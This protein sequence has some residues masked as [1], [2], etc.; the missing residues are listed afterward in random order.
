[1]ALL[2]KKQIQER[3]DIHYRVIQVPQWGN[4]EIKLRSLLLEEQF[5]INSL[6][7]RKDVSESDKILEVIVMCCVDD[8]NN[9]LFEPE[10][11]AW[12]KT[13]SPDAIVHIFNE[14]MNMV[15]I[16]D[17]KL[18]ERAKTPKTSYDTFLILFSKRVGNDTEGT[19]G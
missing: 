3:D 12:L 2:N 13:K 10:D 18:E 14:I 15:S 4:D 17:D 9:Q 11:K 5:V 16:N 7:G 8:K 6:E 1:M 19:D